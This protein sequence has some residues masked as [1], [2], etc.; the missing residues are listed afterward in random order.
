MGHIRQLKLQ[1]L[2]SYA[3]KY[4]LLLQNNLY[5]MDKLYP[6]KFTPIFKDK[7]WGGQKIKTILGKDFSPLYN[8]GELWA[9][10][11]VEDEQSVVENGF[12]EGNELNDL[13]EVYMGE[14]VGEKVFQ[15]Y[16]NVFPVLI[17]FIDSNSYLSL[18][19]H[20]DDKIAM[21]F[22][23]ELFGKNEMWYII[24]ADHDAELISGFSRQTNKDELIALLKDKKIDEVLNIVKVHKGDIFDIPAG[25]VHAIGPGI[26][27]AEIQQ[28][29][30]ITYRIYDW[31]RIGVDGM[32]R[33]L[34]ADLALQALNF[35][36]KDSYKTEYR[37]KLNDGSVLVNNDYFRTSLFEF[38]K[39]LD[40]DNEM[41]DSFVIHICIEGEYNLIYNTD[42]TINIKQGE[43]ILIPADLKIYEILPVGKAKILEVYID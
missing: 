25:R 37:Q 16:G 12:L 1:T 33:E 32:K 42:E 7:I 29:S 6:L 11:G 36:F 31:D 24:E 43:A 28:T 14:L 4:F 26:L 5:C 21:K 41:L 30:D 22:H 15:K 20:P 10:S 35:E 18:Q 17:K 34:H 13:V 40:F 27:L 3:S 38:D 9:I 2:G 23:G 39:K 8:C 19:V